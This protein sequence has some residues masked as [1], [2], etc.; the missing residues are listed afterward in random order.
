MALKVVSVNVN[1]MPQGL[2]SVFTS[3]KM[4]DR[5]AQRQPSGGKEPGVIDHAGEQRSECRGHGSTQLR[6]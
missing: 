5:F 2:L 1:L 4:S 6:P 3:G